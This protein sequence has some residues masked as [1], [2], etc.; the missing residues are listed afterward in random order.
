MKK[1]SKLKKAK[2]HS[3]AKINKSERSKDHQMTEYSKDVDEEDEDN[4]LKEFFSS[5]RKKIEE[6]KV[7]MLKKEEE[8]KEEE[9]DKKFEEW[10]EHVNFLASHDAARIKEEET[11]LASH[12]AARNKDVEELL[13][14]SLAAGSHI[15]CSD[16]NDQQISEYEKK[17]EELWSIEE[18][19][20]NLF[21][22]ISDIQQFI[23]NVKNF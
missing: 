3:I 22:T 20:V 9:V 14:S 19:T 1:S 15:T 11:F 10:K 4:D 17:K 7:D 2:K 5:N 13:L 8:W 12:D 18:G 21:S 16:Q 23:F 6:A